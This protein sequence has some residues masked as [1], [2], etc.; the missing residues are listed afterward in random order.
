MRLQFL[1]EGSELKK[2]DGDAQYRRAVRSIRE[3]NVDALV[4]LIGSG[5][6][7]KRRNV[8]GEGR[9]ATRHDVDVR[10][11]RAHIDQRHDLERIEVV[12]DL[13]GVLNCKN[14]YINEDGSGKME[15]SMDASEMMEMV[16]QMGDGESG[17]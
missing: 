6:E 11:A 12:I 16:S 1:Q 7:L 8:A 3:D 14:I 4:E 9:D 17:G 2:H 5:L 10:H 15:F 13:I